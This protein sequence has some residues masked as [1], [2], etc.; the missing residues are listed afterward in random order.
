MSLSLLERLPKEVLHETAGFLDA[1]ALLNC[2]LVN[3]NISNDVN[4]VFSRR[5]F[6]H[7]AV[8]VNSESL[9]ILRQVSLSVKYR[10]L[11]TSLDVC[12]HHV[13]ERHRHFG[14]KEFSGP[15]RSMIRTN[16]PHY[17]KLLRDQNWLM[18]SGQAA[19]I[20]TLVLKDLPNCIT[21]RIGDLRYALD[22]HRRFQKSNARGLL[23]TE[24]ISPSSVDFVKRLIST[25]MAAI[26]T[27]GR[28]LEALHID[29]DFGGIQIGHLPRFSPNQLGLFFSK[30]SSLALSLSYYNIQNNEMAH[31]SDWIKLFPSLTFL[32]LSFNPRLFPDD[33]SSI[34]QSLHIDGIT[35]LILCLVQCHYDDLAILLKNNRATLRSFSLYEVDL[36]GWAKPWRSILEFIRDETLIDNIDFQFCRSDDEDISF[37]VH[38]PHNHLNVPTESHKFSDELDDIISGL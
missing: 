26:N 24:M 21:V 27:S 2:R 17:A 29:F 38:H 25:T 3:R 14:F 9:N 8:F 4:Y 37:G 30:L 16:H 32:D 18:E 10:A 33:F 12:V 19:A 1:E 34:S 13:P 23:T 6:R 36:I 11:V 28:I 7:R 20:L 15:A 5:F 35:T 31:L 22:F